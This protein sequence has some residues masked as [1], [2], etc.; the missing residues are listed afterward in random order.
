MEKLLEIANKAFPLM[1][2]SEYISGLHDK[3]EIFWD[4]WG[5]PHIFANSIEDVSFSIG[6]I[7]GGHRL[8][9]MELF[10]R[11]TTGELSELIGEASLNSDKYYKIIGFH[12]IARNCEQRLLKNKNS[13][14]YHLLEA[15]KKGVNASIE[16][17][18]KNPPLE[19]SL[20]NLKI[21]DWRL[22]DSLKMA[23]FIDWANASWNYPLELLRERLII[24]LGVEEANKILPL[25]SGVNF[26]NNIGSNGW[27]VSPKK[28]ETGSVLF[29]N[30]PHLS[31]TLPS[32]WFLAHLNCP[33]LNV[34]GVSLPGLPMIVL[35]H[36]E[37]IAWGC[38][39]VHADTVDL[40]K[41]EL[42]PENTNQ[43][44]YNGH[45]EDFSILD[46]PITIKDKAEPF[47]YKIYMT[48]MG[49]I[50]EFFEIDGNLYEVKLPKK[51]A[52][53]WS[54]LE[55]N[56]ENTIETFANLNKASDWND[57]RE[58]L[59][60]LDI[61]PQNF[62]YGDVYGNIG[63]HHGGRIPVRRY[64]D[65]AT[66]TPGYDEKYDW[67]RYSAFEE[68]FFILN[69]ANGFVYNA[70]FNEEK[71]PKGILLAQDRSEPYRQIRL[72]KLLG[73]KKQIS[74][75]D[76]INFQLDFYTE[77]A[78]ELLP[79]MLKHLKSNISSKVFSKLISLLEN[80]DYYLTKETIAGTIFKVWIV[81]TIKSI[82][83]P[84][85]GEEILNPYL[86]PC[87]FELTRLF[88]LYENRNK[89][90]EE[91]FLNSFQLTVKFLSE[92]ISPDYTKWK[93]GNLHKLTLVHPF[94]HANP[95]EA[96]ILN[97]GPYKF[98][99]D[100]NTLNNGYYNPLNNY[101]VITGPSFRQIHD[102]N[103]WDKSICIIPGGQSGMPF[104]KH[105]NDLIKLYNKGKYIPLLFSKGA[106]LNNL[107]AILKLKPK[108]FI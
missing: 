17:A 97:M 69:P 78:P 4:K 77:E 2:G 39:N 32:I 19:F 28:S 94:S 26:K 6:Y 45:W 61:N 5:I 88:K 91:I 56:I 21:Q 43:Y 24:K 86:G 15:Y 90:L 105:Y 99:G 23:L 22:E 72:K 85:I 87:P 29:A 92:K 12:R 84:L 60:K 66:A 59:K 102:L 107:E 89:D 98:G 68:M 82:L 67:E 93:W 42:N 58:S 18:R 53:R 62:I 54:S 33:D 51:Y 46:E 3:V 108:K 35:G 96:K 48:K 14:I 103:D 27:A 16:K 74:F 80:W 71:V 50:I 81:E 49:P 37:K 47:S 63:L 44:M 95:E 79:I 83:I 100:T 7:H 73:A 34:I 57:F 64:G 40:F 104:H 11:V 65:G 75:Q 70:N 101:D 25:Y 1:E 76:L 13:E 38:T 20:L 55:G 106:I 52:L 41:L 10:R 36:N 8:W 31:L 9:Q 30:D